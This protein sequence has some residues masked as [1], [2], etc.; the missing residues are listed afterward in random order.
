[1]RTPLLIIG[2]LTLAVSHRLAAQ[3]DYYLR[4][5]A[6]AWS[7]LVTDFIAQDVRTRPAAGPTLIGG[8]G[9]SIAPRYRAGLE[10]AASSG[11]LHSEYGSVRG[12]LGSLRTASLLGLLDGG[13][14]AGVRWQAGIG[15]L[16][17]FAG[18][19]AGL[20][21]SG[22]T[23]LLVRR[24]AGFPPAARREVR[25]HDRRAVRLP[26]L[27]QPGAQGA[28]LLGRPARRKSLP[29]GSRWPAASSAGCSLHFRV[30]QR[31]RAVGAAMLSDLARPAPACRI[32]T[33]LQQQLKSCRCR[34]RRLKSTRLV[35][36]AASACSS[37]CVRW[38][39]CS[40][41]IASALARPRHRFAPSWASAKAR[42]PGFSTRSCWLIVCSRCPPATGAIVS[43]RAASSHGSSFGGRCLLR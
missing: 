39:C 27:H 9:H 25:P 12:D 35:T 10:L 32:P 7:T 23:R 41:S 1:M 24:R 16:H 26:S 30:N 17:Y 21:A 42:W 4:A 38:R 29:T 15:F 3:T 36:K 8:L 20:L 6:T 5:G 31:H 18:D 14:G 33:N 13:I 28:R 34:S 37:S 22:T 40:I 11:G 2:L 19:E 43:D